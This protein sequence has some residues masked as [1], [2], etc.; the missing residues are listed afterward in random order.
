MMSMVSSSVPSGTIK[1]TGSPSSRGTMNT[2]VS[3]PQ[4]VRTARKSRK[5]EYLITAWSLPP[6]VTCEVHDRRMGSW[7]GLCCHAHLC[8]P[9]PGPVGSSVSRSQSPTELAAN[10]VST[11]AMPGITETHQACWI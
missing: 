3:T 9:R 5:N 11:K 6:E 2:I 10:T 8:R 7:P 4:K 1:N